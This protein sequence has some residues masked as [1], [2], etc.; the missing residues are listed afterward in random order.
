VAIQEKEEGYVGA[1]VSVTIPGYPTNTKVQLKALDY[2]SKGD[3]D[4]IEVILPNGKP[5]SVKKADVKL[6]EAG[7]YNSQTDMEK[8][9]KTGEN[10]PDNVTGNIEMALDGI[11]NAIAN[12]AELKVSIEDS[13][14]FS[15][16]TIDKCIAELTS[17]KTHLNQEKS[18]STLASV[19]G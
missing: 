15:A 18:H 12:L 17:Y 14:S 3:E 11:E 19:S 13:T 7:V 2:T 8:N 9:P 16:E 4:Q 1:V 5:A 6:F 10:K